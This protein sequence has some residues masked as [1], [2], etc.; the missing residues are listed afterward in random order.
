M[1]GSPLAEKK[2]AAKILDILMEAYPQAGVHLDFRNAF[3]LLAAA[4]PASRP[5]VNL[6]PH[7]LL[8]VLENLLD[9][10]ASFA[11]PVGSRRR[12]RSSSCSRRA[13][14]RPTGWRW[15]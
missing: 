4:D 13:W 12:R 5:F 8:Q 7:R 1:P 15:R 14:R 9:N 10:A 11:P 3:Q 6:A 2:R